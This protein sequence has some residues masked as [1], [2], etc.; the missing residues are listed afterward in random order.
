MAELIVKYVH[1]KS[2]FK[3]LAKKTH[4]NGFD[5]LLGCLLKSELSYGLQSVRLKFQDFCS[6]AKTVTQRASTDQ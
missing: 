5:I 3:I 6:T 4:T 2:G 1:P